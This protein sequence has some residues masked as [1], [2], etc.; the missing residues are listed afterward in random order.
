MKTTLDVLHITKQ[1][2]F[3][4]IKQIYWKYYSE[5]KFPVLGNMQTKQIELT[6]LCLLV[7]SY[8]F[9]N[10]QIPNWE[11]KQYKQIRYW[12]HP[13]IKSTVPTQIYHLLV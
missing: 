9:W 4:S 5:V 13:Q 3:G 2:N 1:Y 8:S 6:V 7:P 10:V 12:T 11:R